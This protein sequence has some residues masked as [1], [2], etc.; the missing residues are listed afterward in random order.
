MLV[1]VYRSA[2]HDLDS[3][4]L[5]QRIGSTLSTGFDPQCEGLESQPI[6]SKRLAFLYCHTVTLSAVPT[7]ASC[8]Y[9]R[10]ASLHGAGRF[11]RPLCS[12][13]QVVRGSSKLN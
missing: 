5:S 7:Q 12:T 6:G 13:P 11:D 4:M 9:R 10:R 8:C 2:P 3:L 1:A